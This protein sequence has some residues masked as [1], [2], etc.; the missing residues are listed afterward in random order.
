MTVAPPAPSMVAKSAASDTR[1]RTLPVRRAPSGTKVRGRGEVAVGEG[2][3]PNAWGLFGRR[4]LHRGVRSSARKAGASRLRVVQRKRPPN[5]RKPPAS[6]LPRRE[7]GVRGKALDMPWFFR[8][9]RRFHGGGGRTGLSITRRFSW[10][11]ESIRMGSEQK[12]GFESPL[13]MYPLSPFQVRR[14]ERGRA[15]GGEPGV[16]GESLAVH[17][18]FHMLFGLDQR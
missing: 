11:R 13:S 14:S 16:R 4:V 6:R 5:P 15:V 17:A 9:L 3:C 12:R 18:C 7:W 10:L 2:R 1:A 8:E